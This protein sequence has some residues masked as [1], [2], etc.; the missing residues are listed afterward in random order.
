MRKKVLLVDDSST[1]LL[2]EKMVLKKTPYE[3]VTASNGEEAVQRALQEHPDII[4]MDVI[5][6]KMGGFE[7]LRR[8]R[9]EEATRNTPV[10]MV[11][12]RGEAENVE[13]GYTSGCSDY[14]TKP[15]D[16]MELLAKLRN[17]LEN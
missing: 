6:P 1:I 14:I 11:T 7:A 4:L 15:I 8:L 12:T 9:Q 5:M 2:M 3:V 17:H 16:T 13:Q 10:I